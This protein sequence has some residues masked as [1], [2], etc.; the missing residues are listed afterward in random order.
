MSRNALVAWLLVA[1]PFLAA[2][3]CSR[4]SSADDDAN[5]PVPLDVAKLI[6]P[7]A[8]LF[9]H[10]PSVSALEGKIRAL[11]S[12]ADPRVGPMIDLSSFF[13]K[14]FAIE[15]SFLDRERPVGFA[16]SLPEKKGGEPLATA[17]VPVKNPDLLLTSVKG[18][19]G[20][21]KAVRLGS[22][23]GFSEAPSYASGTSRQGLTSGVAPADATIR[24]DLKKLFAFYQSDI[25]KGIAKAER[26]D[27]ASAQATQM[28][29]AMRGFVRSA[30]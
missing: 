24:A 14:S 4:S 3:S 27:L 21:F 9:V 13:T 30:D 1:S 18:R 15:P 26:N 25:D 29:E 16:L 2:P 23:I 5:S 19:T 28:L 11:A 7:D 10:V 12:I 17:V 22:Y 20:A 8:F 6:P